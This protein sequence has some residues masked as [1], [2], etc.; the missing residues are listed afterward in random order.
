MSLKKPHQLIPA[1]LVFWA[2]LLTAFSPA[3]AEVNLGVTG[4]RMAALGGEEAARYWADF[5][6]ERL[7]E[8]AVLRVFTDDEQLFQWMERYRIV[9]LGLASAK[10][11]QTQPDGRFYTVSQGVTTGT[12][13]LMRPDLSADRQES[14]R[15]HAWSALPDLEHRQ[16]VE[17]ARQGQPDEALRQLAALR[18]A[19]PE[20]RWL[21][22]DTLVV[23]GWA[24]KDA[25]AADLAGETSLD[26]APAY[27]LESVGKSLRN[28]GRFDAAI[29]LYT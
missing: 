19:R 15:H 25:E 24:E 17:L 16:A 8:E 28:L 4:E 2:L 1:L 21:I 9:E 26:E 27:V 14:L 13:L 22:F 5:M 12:L 23:L 29:D 10:A 18:A 6:A 3:R 20:N 7:G 11:A